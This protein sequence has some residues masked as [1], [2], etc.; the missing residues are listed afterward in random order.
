MKSTSARSD[1]LELVKLG[2]ALRAAAD[3]YQT[4]VLD[5]LVPSDAELV[6]SFRSP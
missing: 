3:F 4:P 2:H 5:D 1:C 6:I